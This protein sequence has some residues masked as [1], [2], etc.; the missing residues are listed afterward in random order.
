MFTARRLTV[1]RLTRP[2]SVAHFSFSTRR[3][4]LAFSYVEGPREPPLESS[5]LSNYFEQQLLPRYA[6]KP[7]LICRQE[8]PRAHAGPPQCNL[9]RT[10]C[11]AWS[12]DEFFRHIQ[13]LA[14]GLV[15]L[16][17]K[18]G[19]RVGAVMGNNRYALRRL[20]IELNI[21]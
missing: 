8:L 9:N 5:T 11:L 15:A 13:S 14:R 18:K 10:D 12:F 4:A 19:D 1:G 6:P 20:F 2:S 3:K 17:V 7:A 21:D 16:G